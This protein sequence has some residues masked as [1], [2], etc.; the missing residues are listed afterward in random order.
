MSATQITDPVR[1]EELRNRFDSDS[2]D[3]PSVDGVV[4][5]RPDLRRKEAERQARILN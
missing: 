1:L 3:H 2:F 4:V 5:Y